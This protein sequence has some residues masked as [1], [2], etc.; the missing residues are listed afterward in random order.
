VAENGK[1]NL[2]PNER[3]RSMPKTERRYNATTKIDFFNNFGYTK[4]DNFFSRNIS[5]SK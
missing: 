3:P 1:N 4:P 5:P 2:Y